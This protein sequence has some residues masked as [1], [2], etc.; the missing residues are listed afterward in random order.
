MEDT[1]ISRIDGTIKRRSDYAQNPVATG[2]N[3]LSNIFALDQELTDA[4]MVDL[5][6]RL[7]KHEWPSIDGLLLVKIASYFVSVDE[8]A[9][10]I[11][12]LDSECWDIKSAWLHWCDKEVEDSD[13][14]NPFLMEM[15]D[16]ARET[17]GYRDY[18][19]HKY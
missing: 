19:K 18:I 16:F 15:S 4:K 13:L 2:L 10:F 1:F 6:I 12:I 7:M 8:S 5:T 14:I 17:K 3:G 11:D 9:K